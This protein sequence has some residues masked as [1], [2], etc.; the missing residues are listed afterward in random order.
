MKRILF[1]DDEPDILAG[2]RGAAHRHRS[3]WTAVF[4]ESGEAAMSELAEDGFD[5]VV[6]DMRM[7]GM[8]GAELLRRV[9]SDY[10]KMVRIILSGYA[11]LEVSMRAVPVAHQFL[12]KPC[13]AETL[14]SVI[15]RACDLQALI[16]DD[17]ILELVG[18]INA[19]PSLPKIY[20][21]LNDAL[22]NVETTAVD[23]AA[24]VEQDMTICAKILQLVNSAFFRTAREVS[25][26]EQA[27]VHL[28]TNMIKQL[29]LATEVFNSFPS[30]SSSALVAIQE[31]S[32]TVARVATRLCSD[33]KMVESAF[34]SAILHDIGKMVQMLVVT[35]PI[36][37]IRARRR[38]YGESEWVAETA[39]YGVSHAEVG[40]Y[41]LG[42][43][44][45]PYPI[46]EAVAN[47]H[48]PGRVAVDHF[49]A[50]G[51]V[52]LANGL[53]H[54]IAQQNHDG[55]SQPAPEIDLE[56]VARIGCIDRLPEWRAL[57]E[58]MLA[59]MHE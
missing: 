42:I 13:D 21:Q 14:N 56:F 44:G 41:L 52:H 18:N 20:A 15:Q 35:D 37:E 50:L 5:V 1:V 4:V 49:D 40:G 12:L 11:G 32:L 45:L 10:P 28:G 43:W 54:E 48:C 2:L 30:A 31:H 22:V 47:H 17:K 7:P 19:L 57:T 34:M 38:D 55:D 29:V 59:D 53:V 26:I 27:V 16:A 46:V 3:E 6:T 33:P 58:K 9:N 51:A 36:S 25:S 24:I 39:L 23:I 8:D